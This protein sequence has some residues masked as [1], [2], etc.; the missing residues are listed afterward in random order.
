MTAHDAGVEYAGPVELVAG[1]RK[2]EVTATLRGEFQ[3][4]DG[5]F[6]WYGRLA[7]SADLDAVGSGATVTLRTDHGQAT[8]RLSDVD[9]WG[10][11]RISGTGPP[12]F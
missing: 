1:E 11:L 4:I 2:I 10:R 12:P 6:H 8:G 7:A 3:P 5:R 9:L